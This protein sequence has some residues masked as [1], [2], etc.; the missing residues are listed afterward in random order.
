MN[1]ITSR[2]FS[3]FGLLTNL[4]IVLRKSVIR[5][6]VLPLSAES[7]PSRIASSQWYKTSDSELNEDSSLIDN[8]WEFCNI[9]FSSRKISRK[10]LV[11]V[12]HRDQCLAKGRERSLPAI[13]N[14][15]R[16][17]W[18]DEHRFWLHYAEGKLII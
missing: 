2:L 16:V 13:D 8:I 11:N 7:W 6:F 9:R 3:A 18:R 10:S 17:T 5:T 12:L 4:Y 14:C 1:L 15:K